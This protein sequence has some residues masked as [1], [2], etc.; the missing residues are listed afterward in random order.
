MWLGGDKLGVAADSA[1]KLLQPT[2]TESA[3]L[4]IFDNDYINV[5][6]RSE[7]ISVKLRFIVM[8]GIGNI[9]KHLGWTVW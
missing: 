1:K 7:H 8:F 9:L 3:S 6:K 5:C 4:N 2:R